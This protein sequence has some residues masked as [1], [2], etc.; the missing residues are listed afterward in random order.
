MI[1][2]MS[3]LACHVS[4][5][6]VE[7]RP[8]LAR[9]KV[10]FD[11]LCVAVED[12]GKQ[13]HSET[14]T[15]QRHFRRVDAEDRPVVVLPVLDFTS[16]LLCQ[17]LRKLLAGKTGKALVARL[18]HAQEL[19]VAVEE[20]EDWEEA[21]SDPLLA[22]VAHA[23]YRTAT[24]L[25]RAIA[26]R[27]VT[28]RSIVL[29]E[30]VVRRLVVHALIIR[31]EVDPWDPVQDSYAPVS[32]DEL[33]LIQKEQRKAAKEAMLARR[34]EEARAMILANPQAQF[35]HSWAAKGTAVPPTTV[36]V[37]TM[38]VGRLCGFNAGV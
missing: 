33:R 25:Q 28:N 2:V 37:G 26:K 14:I 7:E 24:R 18:H 5:D 31:G 23:V 21:D 11:A 15:T 29:A 38:R 1:L 36:I 13:F 10:P 16:S 8:P 17:L 12:I 22:E 19:Q 35:M 32:D 4:V 9:V 6:D 27:P 20:E 30:C 34:Q 3:S